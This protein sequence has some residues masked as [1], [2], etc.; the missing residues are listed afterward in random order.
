M[1]TLTLILIR[2]FTENEQT[3]KMPNAQRAVWRQRG[4]VLG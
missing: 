3:N 2:T 1:P 4:R